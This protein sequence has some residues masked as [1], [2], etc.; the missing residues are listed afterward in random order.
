MQGTNNSNTLNVKFYHSK[1]GAFEGL[2]KSSGYSYSTVLLQA[3]LEP[4]HINSCIW[5]KVVVTFSPGHVGHQVKYIKPDLVY[6]LKMV[7]MESEKDLE[8]LSTS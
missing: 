1:L 7:S 3:G 5:V 2:C 6:I 8:H 4:D